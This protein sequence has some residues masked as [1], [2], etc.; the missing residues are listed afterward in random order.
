VNDPRERDAARRQ[1][2][3][4]PLRGELHDD[5]HAPPWPGDV[6]AAV[7]ALVPVVQATRRQ[8]GRAGARGLFRRA[9]SGMADTADL[10]V[11]D[12]RGHFTVRYPDRPELFVEELARVVDTAVQMR[13]RFGAALDHVTLITVDHGPQG[14]NTSRLAGVVYGNLGTVHLNASMF[15]PEGLDA[16]EKRREAKP[17]KHPPRRAEGGLTRADLVTAHEVWHQIELAFQARYYRDS[18]EF[19]RQLGAYFGVATIEHA[20]AHPG[21]AHDRLVQE[22]SAYA[23]TKPLEATAEMAAQWWWTQGLDDAPAVARHFGQV[24]G[25]FFPMAPAR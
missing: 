18:I 19:R 5:E 1:G 12:S 6:E 24:V 11:D 17:S 15:L 20:V 8:P 10:V 3:T 13:W 23:G 25:R 2:W 4:G 9:M 16:M 14:F 22:V 7:A 21:E